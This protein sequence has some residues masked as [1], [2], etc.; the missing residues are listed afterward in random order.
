MMDKLI[1]LLEDK[2]FSG[3]DI[4][5]ITDHNTRIITYPELYNYKTIDEVVYPHNNVTLLYE[6]AENYGHWVC[7][8]KH[9]NG[10]EPYY[11]FFCSYGLKVDKA[12]SFIPEK[13]RKQNNEEFPILSKMLKD[14][15]YPVVYNNYPLQQF[16]D[17]VA[18]CGRHVAFRLV[19]CDLPLNK[20]IKL[21]TR[22]V[23]DPDLLVT[24]LTA[25]IK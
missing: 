10:L 22:S 23:L 20:Y 14:S 17:D 16:Y 6:T 8:I 2:P 7:L 13:F 11:E 21:L 5:T 9:D 1:K 19:M 3:R 12:L 18:S 25:F 24:Y 15:G 4:L